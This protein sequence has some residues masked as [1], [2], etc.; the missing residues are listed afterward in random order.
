M[1]QRVASL[2]IAATLA[3]LPTPAA[4]ATTTAPQPAQAVATSAVAPA[5]ALAPAE[6]TS[7]SG[8]D[9][10]PW[11]IRAY[12]KVADLTVSPSENNRVIQWMYAHPEIS[13][14]VAL[15]LVLIATGVRGRR[16]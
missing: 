11:W 7:G 4:Q 2:A 15:G 14:G 1:N 3:V 8:T 10:A 6:T 16:R 5:L 13:A 12:R 9:D